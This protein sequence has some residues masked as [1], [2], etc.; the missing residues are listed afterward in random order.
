MNFQT[1]ASVESDRRENMFKKQFYSNQNLDSKRKNDNIHILV[2]Q[3]DNPSQKYEEISSSNSYN[4]NESIGIHAA[5]NSLLES[6]NKGVEKEPPSSDKYTVT[7][8]SAEKN[9]SD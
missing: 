7:E 9:L 4:P 2:D 3:W 1:I 5:K 8:E 6:A